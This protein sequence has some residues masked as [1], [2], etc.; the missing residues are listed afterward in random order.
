MSYFLYPVSVHVAFAVAV[1][2]EDAQDLLDAL[3]SVA[4][5]GVFPQIR[6]ISR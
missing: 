4:R 5:V 2:Q 1:Q 3:S 6:G